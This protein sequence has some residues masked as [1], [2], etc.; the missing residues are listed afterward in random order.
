MATSSPSDIV[1][2]L[3][4]PGPTTSSDNILTQHFSTLSSTII[5]PG[6]ELFASAI[7]GLGLR[8][9]PD[10]SP[11]AIA[12][13]EIV[14][15]EAP[16]LQ[17]TSLDNTPPTLNWIIDSVKA[18]SKSDR[19]KFDALVRRADV[20][21]TD[22]WDCVRK[23]IPAQLGAEELD[24]LAVWAGNVIAPD[25]T[26]LEAWSLFPT[27]S[28][29]NH[30]CTPNA[31]LRN[32]PTTGKAEVVIAVHDF[33]PLD[34]VTISYFS[35]ND[36]SQMNGLLM[37]RKERGLRL[38]TQFGFTSNCRCL[39]C[40]LPLAESKNSDNRR[41]EIFEFDLSCSMWLSKTVDPRIVV[42]K[43]EYVFEE[44]KGVF[45]MEGLPEC[46][47]SASIVAMQI[48]ISHSDWLHAVYFQR[49][50]SLYAEI[51]QGPAWLRTRDEFTLDPTKLSKW[52]TREKEKLILFG[53]WTEEPP[54]DER[55]REEYL[56]RL[57]PDTGTSPEVDGLEKKKKQIA[58]DDPGTESSVSK[59]KKKKK[60][61]KK[62]KVSRFARTKY[63]RN[64]ASANYS[65]NSIFLCC[66]FDTDVRRRLR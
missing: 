5:N 41:K 1:A 34:E 63:A 23:P 42:G 54:R 8:A 58:T 35:S 32:N 2:P 7:H 33:Q 53:I 18:L 31:V 22:R 43:M 45:A 3:P 9:T 49:M 44:S 39:C 61:P 51:V 20:L 50:A 4:D 37:P 57:F 52:G 40:S 19:D 17:F 12:I 65:L 27:I 11:S 38:E 28:R 47:L 16:L 26:L 25:R 60:K 13:K 14:L 36:E 10:A 48:F 59:P 30:S 62:K 55:T 21:K 66:A 64:G 15:Q 56:A 46:R 29:V 6:F 24:I